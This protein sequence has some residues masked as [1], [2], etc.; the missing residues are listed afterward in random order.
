MNAAPSGL[1]AG[2]L[3]PFGV[4]RSFPQPYS[5]RCLVKDCGI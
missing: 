4:E 3:R 1:P 5:G 2:G